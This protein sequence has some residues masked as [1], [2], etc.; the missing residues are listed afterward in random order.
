MR[1]IHES[2]KQCAPV[3]AQSWSLVPETQRKINFYLR[4]VQGVTPSG[5]ADARANVVFGPFIEGQ[6]FWGLRSQHRD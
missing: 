5:G 2:D 1:L 3:R 6:C 4:V